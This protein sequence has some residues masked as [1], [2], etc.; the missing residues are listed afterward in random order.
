MNVKPEAHPA[1][2]SVE[3]TP[4]VSKDADA[5]LSSARHSIPEHSRADN[6]ASALESSR[7]LV[8]SFEIA[9]ANFAQEVSDKLLLVGAPTDHIASPNA[10]SLSSGERFENLIK[11]VREIALARIPYEASISNLTVAALARLQTHP[12]TVREVDTALHASAD[13]GLG[14]SKI[15]LE[16]RFT[17]QRRLM[18]ALRPIRESIS[19]ADAS[20]VT[21][22][23]RQALRLQLKFLDS[24]G[25]LHADGAFDAAVLEARRKLGRHFGP[26]AELST[27]FVGQGEMTSDVIERLA[28]LCA[29][30]RREPGDPQVKSNGII[31]TPQTAE[32]IAKHLESGAQ[33]ITLQ[34]D[35]LAM[36]MSLYY[37]PVNLPAGAKGS[38]GHYQG[39]GSAAFVHLILVDPSLK[40]TPA[41]DMLLRATLIQLQRTSAEIAIGRVEATNEVA[42]RAHHTNGWREMPFDAVEVTSPGGRTAR[43]TGHYLPVSPQMRSVLKAPEIR[44]TYS[45]WPTLGHLPAASPSASGAEKLRQD[46]LTT[47]EMVEMLSRATHPAVVRF[48][49]GC[50]DMNRRDWLGAVSMFTEA[51]D[52]FEGAT[53]AGATR[54]L[55]K[56]DDGLS[57]SARGS[58]CELPLAIQA[59][60]PQALVGGICIGQQSAS[61]MG[62]HIVLSG[63]MASDEHHITVKHPGFRN[64]VTVD[65]KRFEG[66]RRWDAEAEESLAIVARLI[67]QDFSPCL[68]SFNG[69]GAT[70]REC[71]GWAERS[72]PVV[73]ISGS[74][75]ETDALANDAN[76]LAMH[77]TVY[78]VPRDAQAL[79][80]V[81]LHLGIIPEPSRNYS[82]V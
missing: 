20:T 24:L 59:N 81:L 17:M 16:D 47:S 19:D 35:G 5:E 72:L 77:P 63:S 29:K 34:R 27:Q 4:R 13:E 14:I 82:L 30:A 54:M 26:V 3:A 6:I 45:D 67:K 2:A 36:G 75:R 37:E 62:E 40:G 42:R 32:V 56:F 46:A 49:G 68:I 74:G 23:Y 33:L 58:I 9:A 51:F 64:Y 38:L 1:A 7:R 65:E 55:A 66:S 41:H 8:N 31:V 25:A 78:V 11:S 60:N 71:V 57:G 79:R 76:F 43:F 73:L 39:L 61:Q 18:Q 70:R 53:L 80:S 15:S 10:P 50:G 52:G 12:V 28:A 69:G 44:A 48:T 22:E 21:L